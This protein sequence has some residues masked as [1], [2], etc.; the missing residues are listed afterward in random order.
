MAELSVLLASHPEID[1]VVGSVHHV[2]GVSIDFDRGTWLRAVADVGEG[3][4]TMARSSSGALTLAPGHNAPREPQG[5]RDLERFLCAYLDAQ[6]E[7]LRRQQP[8]V[9]GHFDLCLLWT[10]DVSLQDSAD[11]WSKVVRNVEYAVG[12]GA[13]FEANAAAVRKG[14][15]SSYPGPDVLRLIL[16]TGGRICLSDDSH[17]VAF[18]GLNYAKM[19]EY[20]VRE[21]VREVWYLVPAAEGGETVGTRGRVKARRLEG[22]DKDKFWANADR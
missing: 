7:M 17:G 3:G 20:L 21:G 6:F 1:Y 9:V 4:T 15:S 2:D 18:V 19:R 5:M 14:W 8:E 10:P 22:W 16:A 13:L 11:V 12:Y